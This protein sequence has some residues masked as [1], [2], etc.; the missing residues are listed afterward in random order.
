M[1]RSYLRK[2]KIKK[3]IKK[4]AKF[5]ID[6]KYWDD[7]DED[8]VPYWEKTGF[9]DPDEYNRRDGEIHPSIQKELE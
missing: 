9:I 7:Y 1:I 4:V 8:G 6:S 2:R 5:K 3:K